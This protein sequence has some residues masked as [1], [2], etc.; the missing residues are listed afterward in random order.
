V[1]SILWAI[2]DGIAFSPEWLVGPLAAED[3]LGAAQR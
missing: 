3:L 1:L 2:E